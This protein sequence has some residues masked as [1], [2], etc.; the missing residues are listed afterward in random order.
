MFCYLL[1]TRLLVEVITAARR[2]F[3]IRPVCHRLVI[4]IFAFNSEIVIT[5]AAALKLVVTL[6]IVC[7]FRDGL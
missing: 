4:W 1:R 6:E 7:D 5:C 2:S 3:D